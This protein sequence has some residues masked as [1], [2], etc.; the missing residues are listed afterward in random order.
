MSART[1]RD[2][3][4]KELARQLEGLFDPDTGRADFRAISKVWEQEKGLI[5][6]TFGNQFETV[7]RQAGNQSF[8]L[9][10]QAGQQAGKFGGA[11]SGIMD[12]FNRRAKEM[13]SVDYSSSMTDIYNKKE[14]SLLGASKEFEEKKGNL[15]T[16]F[17]QM[18]AELSG[19]ES[20]YGYDYDEFVS[21][22]NVRNTITDVPVFGG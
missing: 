22:Y 7:G 12:E 11:S 15:E 10:Q 6:T 20:K 21:W 3:Y 4:A 1:A 17:N 13:L 18:L 19:V 2:S 14:V 5:N 9:N 16:N 8:G